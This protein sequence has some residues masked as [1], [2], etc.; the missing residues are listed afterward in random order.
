MYHTLDLVSECPSY[1]LSLTNLRRKCGNGAP[2]AAI[3]HVFFAQVIVSKRSLARFG[4]R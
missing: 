4:R 1:F 3:E 2:A